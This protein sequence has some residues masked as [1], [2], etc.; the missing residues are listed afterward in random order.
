MTVIVIEGS[1]ERL[2]GALSIAAAHAALGGNARIFLQGEAVRAIREPLQGWEDDTHEDAGL[3]ALAI[4]FDEALKLG[5]RIIACQ[6]GLQLANARPE[7]FDPRVD[8]GGLVSV[9]QDLGEDRLVT[10]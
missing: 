1:S 9:M 10:V 7:D 3:P 2:R 5:V 4:L 6:S 8:Y